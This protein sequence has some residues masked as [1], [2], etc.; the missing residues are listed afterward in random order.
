M[1]EALPPGSAIIDLAA[2][3]GGNCSLTRLG[4]WVEA[5]DVSIYGPAN[6]PAEMPSLSS[7]LYS[8]NV[9][10]FLNEFIKE[11]QVKLDL[12]NEVIK[13]MLITHEGKIVH[14]ATLAALQRQG[15]K[16]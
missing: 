6:L 10:T 9:A 14:E 12:S 11:G 5:H 13:G 4:Q 1:V 16:A 2:P 7:T 15:T 8:R 3:S